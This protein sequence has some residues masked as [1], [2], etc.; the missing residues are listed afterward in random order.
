MP[1]FSDVFRILYRRG[2]CMD[3]AKP[4]LTWKHIH[5]NAARVG[6]QWAGFYKVTTDGHCRARGGLTSRTSG[7]NFDSVTAPHPRNRGVGLHKMSSTASRPRRS[8]PIQV[9][10][11]KGCL[12][13][14]DMTTMLSS[15]TFCVLQTNLAW[16]VG[17]ALCSC[18]LWM[19]MTSCR[20]AI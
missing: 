4:A 10:T 18:V 1:A 9:R 13:S 8:L 6:P 12:S 5:E 14:R 15:G 7:E 2:L 19:H 17:W 3:V 16:D 20:S 11:W